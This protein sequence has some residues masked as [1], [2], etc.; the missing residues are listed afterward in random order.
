MI[1]PDPPSRELRRLAAILAA[2]I[3]GYSRL[4]GTDEARTVRE[5]KAH[6]AVVFPMIGEFGGRIIDTAGDG[7]LAEF[8]SILNAV[9]CAIEIQKTMEQRNEAVQPEWKMRFRIGINQGDVIY[10]E[11][12]VYG[13]GINIAGPARPAAAACRRAPGCRS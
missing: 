5:L 6:Q 8:A 13:D 11:N 2:D 7:I 9:N 1:M 10:D 12:R 4:M 3:E